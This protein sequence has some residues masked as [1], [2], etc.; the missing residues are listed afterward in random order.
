LKKHA[1]EIELPPTATTE[2]P[3][4]KTNAE[5]EVIRG[6]SPLVSGF[7][8]VEELSVRVTQPVEG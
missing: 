7:G 5:A 1:K 8:A 3:S 6:T 4:G 2:K